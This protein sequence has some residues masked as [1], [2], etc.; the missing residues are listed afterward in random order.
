MMR[1]RAEEIRALLLA[2]RETHDVEIDCEEFLGLMATYAEARIEGKPI[3]DELERAHDH[4]RLC[5]NCHEELAALLA[6][7]SEGQG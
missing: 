7:L 4:E 5:A 6:M 3:A 1:L 2:S